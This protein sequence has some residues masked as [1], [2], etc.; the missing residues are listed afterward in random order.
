M[1]LFIILKIPSTEVFFI[2]IR[3]FF[4]YFWEHERSN[5]VILYLNVADFGGLCIHGSNISHL[6]R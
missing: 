5:P 1:Q 4:Y 6:E 3:G 2:E